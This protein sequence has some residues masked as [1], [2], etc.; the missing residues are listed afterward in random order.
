MLFRTTAQLLFR[1]LDVSRIVRLMDAVPHNA[2]SLASHFCVVPVPML[3]HFVRVT[4][5]SSSPNQVHIRRVVSSP[6]RVG[7]Y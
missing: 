6:N 2:I 3:C 4:S 1:L 5:E 7:A